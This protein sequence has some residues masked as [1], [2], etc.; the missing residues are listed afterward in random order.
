MLMGAGPGQHPSLGHRHDKSPARQS[1]SPFL[2]ASTGPSQIGC[3]GDVDAEEEEE[4]SR[5]YVR[6]HSP[7]CLDQ[8]AMMG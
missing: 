3:T 5:Y 8:R 2:G 4:Q 7:S 6:L 1:N